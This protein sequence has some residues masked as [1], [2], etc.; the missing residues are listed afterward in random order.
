VS[1]QIA[2]SSLARGTRSVLKFNS[3]WTIELEDD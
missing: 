3:F 2:G 1:E